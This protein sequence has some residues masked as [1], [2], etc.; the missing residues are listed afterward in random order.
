MKAKTYPIPGKS[1]TS[2]NNYLRIRFR[3]QAVETVEG[4]CKVWILCKLCALHIATYILSIVS[5]N[6]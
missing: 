3:H 1:G 6:K 4:V 5:M 2:C